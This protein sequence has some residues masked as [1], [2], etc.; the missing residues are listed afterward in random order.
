M[1]RMGEEEKFFRCSLITLEHFHLNSWF[2]FLLRCVCMCVH[3]RICTHMHT[4]EGIYKYIKYIIYIAFCTELEN[5]F[6][7]IFLT[8]DILT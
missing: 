6:V 8:S 2:I 4:L 1:L 7:F 3:I 5:G